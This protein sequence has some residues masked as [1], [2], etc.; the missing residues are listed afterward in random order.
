MAYGYTYPSGE[1]FGLNSFQDVVDRYNKV[2]QL[3][4]PGHPRHQDIRPIGKRSRKHE[5]V[6]KISDNCYV[7]LTGHNMADDVFN[8]H[9]V[10]QSVVAAGS[11]VTPR[12][13]VALAPICWRRGKGGKETIKIRNGIGQYTHNAHY[14]F[15][16]R[17][18]PQGLSWRVKSGKQF[19]SGLYLPKTNYAPRYIVER[20]QSRTSSLKAKDDGAA[21]TFIRAG[22]NEFVFDG[23]AHN[24]PKSPRVDRRLKG[25]YKK[26]IADYLAWISAMAP[27]LQTGDR[28]YCRK[29]REEVFDYMGNYIY[30]IAPEVMLQIITEPEHPLRLHMA[31]DFVS[32]YGTVKHIRSSDDISRV[33]TEYNRWINI[34]CR[35]K[36]TTNGKG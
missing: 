1:H 10:R 19:V 15:L 7:L 14:S 30:P 33:R 4:S 27:M 18:L 34:R 2:K 22:H 9:L 11:V 17:A 8:W 24:P 28:S 16:Q 13:L 6:K 3:V 12:E 20:P 26:A 31:V 23:K 5:R 25:K 29:M 32:N 21:L 36:T 35:F